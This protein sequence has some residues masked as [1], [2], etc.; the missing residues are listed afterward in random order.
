MD[1][2]VVISM[3]N[4]A[5]NTDFSGGICRPSF[6][7]ACCLLIVKYETLLIMLLV[8]FLRFDIP[9]FNDWGSQHFYATFAT[10]ITCSGH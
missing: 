10:W 8:C 4:L 2:G 6:G 3:L 7:H 5:C 9:D 1:F